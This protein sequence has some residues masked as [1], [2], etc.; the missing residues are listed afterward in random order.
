MKLN[1]LS[2]K[3]ENIKASLGSGA[4]LNKANW[5]GQKSCTCLPAG[6]AVIKVFDADSVWTD[7]FFTNEAKWKDFAPLNRM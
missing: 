2:V 7:P 4:A 5:G 3:R 6:G 1:K